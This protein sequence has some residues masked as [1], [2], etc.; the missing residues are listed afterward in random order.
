V[1]YQLIY[2]DI[3]KIK[4][5]FFMYDIYKFLSSQQADIFGKNKKVPSDGSYQEKNWLKIAVIEKQG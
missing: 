4:F 3:P 5:E 1:T 2:L